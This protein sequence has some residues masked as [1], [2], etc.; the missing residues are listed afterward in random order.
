VLVSVSAPAS[1]PSVQSG[2]CTAATVLSDDSV[3]MYATHDL[4]DGGWVRLRVAGEPSRT[5]CV[6]A[7]VVGTQ[8]AR[9]HIEITR[10]YARTKVKAP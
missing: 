10:E 8:S 4:Q 2:A 7:Y 6:R 5:P 3:K 1:S 9:D